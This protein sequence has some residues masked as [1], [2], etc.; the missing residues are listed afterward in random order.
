MATLKS[1][2][3]ELAAELIGD[4]FA[5]FAEPTQIDRLGGWNNTTQTS[6]I[7][8]T[9]TIPTIR[10]EFEAKQFDNDLIKVGDYKLVGEYDLLTFLPSPSNC[11]AT[12]LGV[13]CE[14]KKIIADPAD[15]TIMLHV[16]PR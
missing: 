11:I 9:V 15:A 7:D 13:V 2:F 14:I 6:T 16:R 4:E 1:E 12:R 10:L 3:V 5:D 8:S